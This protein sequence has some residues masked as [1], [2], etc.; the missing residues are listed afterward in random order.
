MNYNTITAEQLINLKLKEVEALQGLFV[1]KFKDGSIVPSTPGRL[2]I[3]W[4]VWELVRRNP[5]IELKPEHCVTDKD[6]TVSTVD[7]IYEAIV[8][9]LQIVYGKNYDCEKVSLDIYETQNLIYNDSIDR[10]ASYVTSIDIFD[11]TDVS[12]HPD[13]VA[14]RE[15]ED[16]NDEAISN[17]YSVVGDILRRPEFK[18]NA[19]ARATRTKTVK[20]AS[21][22][23]TD[24]AIG[25]LR[26]FDDTIF[27]NVLRNG[28]VK[29]IMRLSDLLAESR[30]TTTSLF[31][32]S[33]PMQQSEWFRRELEIQTEVVKEVVGDVCTDSDFYLSVDSFDCGTDQLLAYELKSERE[34]ELFSG[35]MYRTKD[36]P[37]LR[38]LMPTDKSLIGELIMVRTP[39][40]CKHMER[41]KVCATCYGA[42]AKSL[43]KMTNI[44]HLAA[45]EYTHGTSQS[46]VG[47][48]HLIASASSMSIL[49]D[50]HS[51]RF[52]LNGSTPLSLKLNSAIK[53]KARLYIQQKFIKNIV[54]VNVVEDFRN[55]RFSR[56]GDIYEIM[57]EMDGVLYD[58]PTTMSTTA[59]NL[60]GDFLMYAKEK[61][62]TTDRRKYLVFDLSEWDFSKDF[63]SYPMKGASIYE[64]MKAVKHFIF[65]APRKSDREARLTSFVDPGDGLL[66]LFRISSDF[67]SINIV[68]Q[69]IIVRAMMVTD[70]EAGDY[71]LPVGDEKPLLVDQRRLM[72]NRSASAML[73]WQRQALFI[74]DPASYI[75]LD[76]PSQ[77]YDMVFA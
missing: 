25:S 13:V 39:V 11:F 19:K 4:Q 49:L 40:Y 17:L 51:K 6:Y 76:R 14:A 1:L 24:G 34:L 46:V 65:N 47:M 57:I 2:L 60:T 8:K 73:S 18:M 71:R 28:Y 41:G 53:G 10:Y 48:K 16:F 55:Y 20:P 45:S 70:I 62:W 52:I 66:E 36:E 35:A 15:V 9:D 54:D 30:K 74:N 42:I 26:D 50:K 75:Y 38:Q 68:H 3:T 58:I 33:T 69:A 44:G 63:L 32:Q 43:P 64:K 12:T 22:N 31:Y 77:S 59:A 29:G 61:G 5:G 21:V 7:R 37:K 72:L 27:P 67:V 56:I 23:Q